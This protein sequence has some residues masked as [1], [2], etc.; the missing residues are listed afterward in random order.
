LN[1]I[2]RGVRHGL[3][4]GYPPDRH[5]NYWSVAA[6]AG[7]LASRASP[8]LLPIPLPTGIA[9]PAKPE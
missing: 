6:S 3:R 1:R 4:V 2:A 9:Y 5:D 7:H 8:G